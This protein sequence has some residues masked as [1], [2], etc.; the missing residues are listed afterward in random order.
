MVLVLGVSSVKFK[1]KKIEKE[2]MDKMEVWDDNACSYLSS[3]EEW[4]EKE[5][6]KDQ[7]YLR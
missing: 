5:K 4:Q 2:E 7:Q 6:E 1:I 3:K